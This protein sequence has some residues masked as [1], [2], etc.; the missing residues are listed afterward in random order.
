MNE[1]E[2]NNGRCVLLRHVLMSSSY[3]GI[4]VVERF[5]VIIVVLVT[6]VSK[7]TPRGR[8]ICREEWERGK[9]KEGKGRKSR[10]QVTK[11]PGCIL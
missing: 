10:Q 7:R 1:R 8:E 3:R 4:Q 6:E 5:Q 2:V 11:A 9:Q